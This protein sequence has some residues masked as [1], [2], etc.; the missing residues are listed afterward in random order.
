[1]LHIRTESRFTIDPHS[2]FIHGPMMYSAWF[3]IFVRLLL[4]LMYVH[5]LIQYIYIHRVFIKSA[6]MFEWS[7]IKYEWGYI[8]VRHYL[9]LSVFVR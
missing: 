2:W 6:P 5:Q 3:I 7:C 9:S 8:N 1:M 4:S